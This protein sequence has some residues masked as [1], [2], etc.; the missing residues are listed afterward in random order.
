MKKR[1]RKIIKRKKARWVPYSLLSLILSLLLHILFYS[2]FLT[3]P[4]TQKHKKIK[5]NI[6]KLKIINNKK[7]FPFNEKKI[8]ETHFEKTKKP[9]KSKY[10]GQEDHIAKK[11]QKYKK[12]YLNEKKN[13]DPGKNKKKQAKAANKKR[14]KQT[15]LRKPKPKKELTR[16][17]PPKKNLKPRKVFKQGTLKIEPQQEKKETKPTYR[18]LM[19]NSLE[20]LQREQKE[21]FQDHIEDEMEEGDTIDLSTTKFRYIGYF[22]NLRKQIEMTWVYPSYAAKNGKQGNV[23]LEFTIAKNGHVSNVKVLRSSGYRILDE[24]I[25]QA[26]NEASPF[27]PLPKSF[28][29]KKLTITGNFSYIISGYSTY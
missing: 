22:T 13:L 21:T 19:A 28:N 2:F 27:A 5:D 26:I 6:V 20:L 1:L 24:S 10:L 16:K 9:N 11:E 15:L 7:D 25:V 23:F 14:V 8:I 29:K 4:K 17:P 18:S 3:I 12:K